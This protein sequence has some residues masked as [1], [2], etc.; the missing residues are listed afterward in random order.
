MTEDIFPL[1]E[2]TAAK[3]VLVHNGKVL[4]LRESG[5]YVDG[6][7]PGKYDIPGGRLN[8]GEGWIEG[9]R[10]EV[11]EET[12]LTVDN[13]IPFWTRDWRVTRTTE[14]WH[15]RAVFFVVPVETNQ[16]V[17]SVDHDH[18]MWIDPCDVVTQIPI[19][20]GYDAMLAALQARLPALFQHNQKLV[21]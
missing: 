9:L 16:V 6:S 18:Y 10:R 13:P 20:P 7:N 14:A 15:V 1:R 17:L 8:A 2:F 4:F 11:F 5:S 21:A 19:L 3:G 12:G